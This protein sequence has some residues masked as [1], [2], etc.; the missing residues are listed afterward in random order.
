MCMVELLKLLKCPEITMKECV[1]VLLA[2]A[3]KCETIV[4][5][6]F[7]SDKHAMHIKSKSV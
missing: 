4:I 2:T 3:Q 1:R 6:T 5:L 7:A